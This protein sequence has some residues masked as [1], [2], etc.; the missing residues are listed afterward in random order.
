MQWWANYFFSINM[1]CFLIAILAHVLAP[2][3]KIKSIIAVLTG[4]LIGSFL[5]AMIGAIFESVCY[6]LLGV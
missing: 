2:K 5:V 6:L 4:V 3:H 1:I